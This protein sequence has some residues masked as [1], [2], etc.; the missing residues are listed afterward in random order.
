[1]TRLSKG[2][3]PSD[4]GS[5]LNLIVEGRNFGTTSSGAITGTLVARVY[6]EFGGGE[7]RP[8]LWTSDSSVQCGNPIVGYNPPPG[9]GQKSTV[10]VDLFGQEGIL[11]E[12]YSYD[13]PVI[14]RAGAY[15][16]WPYPQSIHNLPA[17][18]PSELSI[19]GRNFGTNDFSAKARVGGTAC[20]TTVWQSD[21]A[22]LCQVVGGHSKA[23]S[24]VVSVARNV[25][26]LLDCVTFDAPFIESMTPPNAPAGGGVPV[27][28][29]GKNFGSQKYSQSASIGDT[30]ITVAWTSDSSMVGI[31]P[32]GRGLILDVAVHQYP[33]ATVGPG[34]L[35]TA[36]STVH[37]QRFT[38]DDPSIT[39]INPPNGPV[40]GNFEIVLSGASFSA[41]ANP[42]QNQPSVTVGQTPC[43]SA[44]WMSDEE[45]RCT[46]A[47][48][49]GA[50]SV[51][52]DLQIQGCTGNNGACIAASPMPFLYDGPH[53]W[54]IKGDGV[55]PST[56]GGVLT[57]T[58]TL[59]GTSVYASL[60]KAKIGPTDCSTSTWLSETSL[61]CVVPE[62]V[63]TRDVVVDLA[64]SANTLSDAFSYESPTVTDVAPLNGPGS[65]GV[66]MIVLGDKFGHSA[67]LDAPTIEVGGREV[68][69]PALASSTKMVCESPPGFRVP[70][71]GLEMTYRSF[72]APPDQAQS[73][74]SRFLYDDLQLAQVTPLVVSGISGG[75]SLTVLGKNFGGVDSS[76]VVFL[77][78][79]DPEKGQA[80]V[81][82]SVTSWLSDSSIQ[83]VSPTTGSGIRDVH[84]LAAGAIG[85]RSV[86]ALK[87][88]LADAGGDRALG[89]TFALT[90]TKGVSFVNMPAN[91]STGSYDIDCGAGTVDWVAGDELEGVSFALAPGFCDSNDAP[92]AL[93]YT[94]KFG[95][96]ISQ[97][98]S[99]LPVS[100]IVGLQ[101][102]GLEDATAYIS[103]SFPVTLDNLSRRRLLQTASAQAGG[104][105]LRSA[106]LDQCEGTWI[107]LCSI[108]EYN[109]ATRKLSSQVPAEVLKDECS[110]GL[111]VPK[112]CADQVAEDYFCGGGILLSAFAYKKDPCLA[113]PGIGLLPIILGSVGGFLLLILCSFLAIRQLRLNRGRYHARFLHG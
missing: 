30:S 109:S 12:C 27:T 15:L 91:L 43:T 75:S 10:S 67:A 31:V 18:E 48:G 73:L 100:V 104:Y 22:L 2:N 49:I 96:T 5:T 21:S 89:G 57:I 92:S 107:P 99:I 17:G 86:A 40:A 60:L 102:L 14:E 56:G 54:A 105:F 66:S 58:G 50:A 97:V 44:L 13:L 88:T 90:L 113:P 63:G 69:S 9:V 85:K 108:D 82:C 19:V 68:K 72:G 45:I 24:V 87:D 51:S 3:G 70:G 25:A 42:A 32:P 77:G 81:A 95:S 8:S 64:G 74:S 46:V 6:S 80:P 71:S 41:A 11:T 61:T 52:L 112:R 4:G 76:P 65:G 37:L 110:G 94:L 79:L 1:M 39:G 93:V 33:A 20:I 29:S 83:C 55:F 7:C 26:S 62:G 53:P 59:F 36:Q 34:A 111:V 28:L 35:S 47:A 78:S 84:L 106:F 38:Y 16:G 103:V 98:N 23:N 101:L